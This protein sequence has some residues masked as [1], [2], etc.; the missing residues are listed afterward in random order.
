[1]G[2]WFTEEAVMPDS[3]AKLLADNELTVVFIESATAGYLSHRFSVS[4]YSGDVLMGGLVCYDVSLKKNVLNVSS[5]L[6]DKYTAES[7][8]VTHELVIKSKKMF[9]ADLHVACTGLLKHGG[10]E[11][12]E[13]PV[14]T[15]FY[16]I[17]YD[18]KVY[19]FRCLCSGPPEQKLRSLNSLI[20]KSIIGV[21]S[22]SS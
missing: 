10:S 21:V 3:C 20:C 8:E 11:T 13:K 17:G 1:M 16:C 4:P 19:D 2:F 14:G 7:L 9:D 18:N 12:K 6:I 5:Q 22:N 15:F